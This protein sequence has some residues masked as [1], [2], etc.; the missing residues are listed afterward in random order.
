MTCRSRHRPG[1]TPAP[2]SI[3]QDRAP[4]ESRWPSAPAATWP[5]TTW[6][7]SPTVTSPPGPPA[8]PMSWPLRPRRPLRPQAAPER[9]R[10]QQ[11][12]CP[13]LTPDRRPTAARAGR[14][15]R[16]GARG[17]PRRRH[18]RRPGGRSARAGGW[19]SPESACLPSPP[20]PRWHCSIPA[21]TH[22]R[23]QRHPSHM[24]IG[25]SAAAAQASHA[26]PSLGTWQ[27]I[28]TRAGDPS[29]A[30]AQPAVP[31][32]VHG[33]EAPATPGRPRLAALIAPVP[34]SARNCR[35]LCVSRVAARSCGP[36]TWPRR[37]S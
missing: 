4:A 5:T 35:R 8:S 7:T 23:R 25:G 11:P 3:R 30:H 34:Y 18:A 31:G 26:S 10:A 16:P 32:P 24:L 1:P 9:I 17:P 2:P 29:A 27:H 33:R 37:R 22:P 15:G 14:R 13:S 19:S 20:S 21:G 12:A 36:A 6:P 28:A